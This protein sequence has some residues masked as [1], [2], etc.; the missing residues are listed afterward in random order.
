[1]RDEESPWVNGCL[2][3]IFIGVD[4]KVGIL[5][6]RGEG[7]SWFHRC[8]TWEISNSTIIAQRGE[9]ANTDSSFVD[10]ARLKSNNDR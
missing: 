10:W 5:A 7:A 4:L 1:V 6:E 3:I 9:G 2:L 8:L